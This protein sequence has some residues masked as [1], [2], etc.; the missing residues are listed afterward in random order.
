M[1][2]A[3]LLKKITLKST[4]VLLLVIGTGAILLM[5]G[6]GKIPAENKDYFEIALGSWITWAGMA[7]KRV[8]DGSDA[9]DAKN[10]TI[11]ALSGAVVTAQA[12]DPVK[13]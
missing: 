2:E 8:L 6:S 5:L 9:S 3:E 12:T 1:L 7:V 10:D 11:A 13:P 4:V